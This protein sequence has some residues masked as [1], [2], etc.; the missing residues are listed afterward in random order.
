M[1]L[2]KM[3]GAAGYCS[4]RQASRLIDAGR[5]EV[6]D[7]IAQHLTFV[8]P[9]DKIRID[10]KE[11]RVFSEKHYVVYHKPVGIDC[12]LN[13]EDPNSLCHVIPTSLPRVFPIGRLDKDSSGLLLLT[14]DGELTNRLLHPAFKQEKCYEVIVKPSFHNRSTNNLTFNTS[15][16]SKM[17]Q[18][19]MIKGKQTAA[20]EIELLDELS[21]N[22]TLTQGLNRQIRRMCSNLG[23]YVTHLKRISLANI[24]LSELAVGDFRSLSTDEIADLIALTNRA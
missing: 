18:P 13:V 11:I 23:F 5:V 17:N 8:A 1:R 3:I 22:I 6:N 21:F 14:N 20:C 9:S 15:F 7:S 10:G 2:A 4:R 12:N 24:T 16:V 19:L